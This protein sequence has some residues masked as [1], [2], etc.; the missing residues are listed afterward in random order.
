MYCE[1]MNNGAVPKITPTWDS[2]VAQQLRACRAEAIRTY[3]LR[4]DEVRSQMMK[5]PLSESDLRG[6]HQ[7]SKAE[8]MRAVVA[9]TFVEAGDAALVAIQGE[10]DEQ[11]NH[12]Y[13]QVEGENARASLDRCS[14]VAERICSEIEAKLECQGAVNVNY[15]QL[16]KDWDDA[17]KVYLRETPQGAP[18]MEI[19]SN[20]VFRRMGKSA[21]RLCE[22][23]IAK[24]KAAWGERHM[25]LERQLRERSKRDLETKE[26]V[27]KLVRST[28]RKNTRSNTAHEQVRR[29][30]R[31]FR[32]RPD[33]VLATTPSSSRDALDDEAWANI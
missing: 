10:V 24:Q 16:Q 33:G 14:A 30:V 9:P 20:C 27:V 18:Q 13:D 4:M 21:E 31:G 28:S 11:I 32:R 26:L 6:K 22:M 25:E 17:R 7:E 12:I 8:A 1:A 2:V 29:L 15:S 23:E 3:R 5:D 19:F